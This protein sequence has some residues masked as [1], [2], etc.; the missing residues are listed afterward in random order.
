MKMSQYNK[1]L[2]ILQQLKI[3]FPKYTLGQHLSTV[4]DE[5]KNLWGVNDKDLLTSLIEYQNQLQTDIP[6]DDEV[7]EIIKGG[8][9]LE[10]LFNANKEHMPKIDKNKLALKL[11]ELKQGRNSS[12]IVN[13]VETRIEDINST[14]FSGLL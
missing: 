2:Q 1:C 4:V 12:A 10:N 5:Y 9:D 6:H 7:D 3:N 11:K 14:I 13:L 8:M